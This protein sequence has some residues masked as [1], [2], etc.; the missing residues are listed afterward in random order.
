M[1]ELKAELK[2]KFGVCFI[3]YS[4]Q[5]RKGDLIMLRAIM[6]FSLGLFAGKFIL[7]TKAKE[8]ISKGAEKA[9][10]MAQQGAEYVKKEF[11]SGKKDHKDDIL[12]RRF[13]L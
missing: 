3:F 13:S 12:Y 8:T 7:T 10:G 1:A 2:I 4:K 9:A 5:E 11:E 6:W